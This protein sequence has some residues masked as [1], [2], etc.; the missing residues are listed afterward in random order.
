MPFPAI[1]NAAMIVSFPV[2]E[3]G[4]TD[5]TSALWIGFCD[6]EKRRSPFPESSAQEDERKISSF[7]TRILFSGRQAGEKVEVL[8]L[9]YLLGTSRVKTARRFSSCFVPRHRP[10]RLVPCSIP[11]FF[12]STVHAG[13]VIKGRR[14][15][16]SL[17][18]NRP[19]P[20]TLTE[21][22]TRRL[23]FL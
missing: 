2:F 23:P 17:F 5:K 14:A 1:K 22:R 7:L 6:E 10:G 12:S 9:G 21:A 15:V 8:P 19:F 20:A 11:F 13:A 3:P 4:I 18:F 16:S